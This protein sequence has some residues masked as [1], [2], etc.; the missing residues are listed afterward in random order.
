MCKHI[1]DVDFHKLDPSKGWRKGPLMWLHIP[2]SEASQGM[3][4]YVDTSNYV[5]AIPALF[6]PT[7]NYTDIQVIQLMSGAAMRQDIVMDKSCIIAVL[8][9]RDII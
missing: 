7:N 3:V 9:D 4:V 8:L 5:R 6:K 2:T 1:S